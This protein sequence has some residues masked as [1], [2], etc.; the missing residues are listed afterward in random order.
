MMH[1]ASDAPWKSSIPSEII[2]TLIR[3]NFFKDMIQTNS[4]AVDP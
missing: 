3:L 2:V 1:H 4:M